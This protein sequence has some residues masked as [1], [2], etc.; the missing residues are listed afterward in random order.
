MSDSYKYLDHNY[1]YTDPKT[2]VLKNLASITDSDALLFFE[3]VAVSKRIKELYEN[4]LKINGI[5][6]L[7]EIHKHLFQ[8]VYAWA[9][10]KRKVEISKSGKQFFPTTYFEQ[11]AIPRFF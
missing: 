8:D 6:S 9:G 2:G 11:L 4:P 5:N 7:F 3:S 1:T 10:K